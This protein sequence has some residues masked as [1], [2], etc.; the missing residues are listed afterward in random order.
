MKEVRDNPM[1]SAARIERERFS[2]A[3]VEPMRTDAPLDL[4]VPAGASVN[5]AESVGFVDPLPT[6]VDAAIREAQRCI[7]EALDLDGC[8]LFEPNDD[9]DLLTSYSWWRPGFPTPPERVSARECFPWML[10][11]LLERRRWSTSHAHHE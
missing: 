11:R 4:R 1:L 8:V 2:R 7:V 6:G 9:G 5:H 3:V 10:P